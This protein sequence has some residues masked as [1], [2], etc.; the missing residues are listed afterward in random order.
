MPVPAIGATGRDLVFGKVPRVHDGVAAIV[1]RSTHVCLA[2]T[3]IIAA[4]AGSA[5]VLETSADL[6]GSTDGRVGCATVGDVQVGLE[7]LDG[8]S[9]GA[10]TVGFGDKGDAVV[11]NGGELALAKE[12]GGAGCWSCCCA[13]GEGPEGGG[14]GE[15]HRAGRLNKA[16]ERGT[17]PRC[18][19]SK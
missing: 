14:R 2:I 11:G 9:F 4:T 19:K 12:G 13:A 16:E 7:A 15:A 1:K 10:A 18:R 5:G 8:V 6:P 17:R 3:A